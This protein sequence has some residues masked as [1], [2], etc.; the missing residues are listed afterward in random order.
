MAE[1]MSRWE[2]K[3]GI[4]DEEADHIRKA[5]RGFAHTATT[6]PFNMGGWTAAALVVFGIVCVY[7]NRVV[8]LIEKIRHRLFHHFEVTDHVILVQSLGFEHELH[9]PRMPMW[10]TTLV[11]VF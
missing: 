7:T 1:D 10:K 8:V 11:R 5:V 3:E 9:T 4:D 6:E 2:A